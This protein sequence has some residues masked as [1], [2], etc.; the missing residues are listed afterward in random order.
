MQ[1]AACRSCSAASCCCRVA[2]KTEPAPEPVRAVRTVTVAPQ[3]AGGTLGVCRRGARPHRV[4]ARLPGRRQDPA[5]PRRPGQHRQG[6][7]GAGATRSAGP[8]SSARTPRAPRWRPRRPTSTLPAADFK[9]F[10]ELR[11]QGFISAAELER[12]ETTLK[13]A[14]AQLD[15]ARAQASVQGNQAGYATLRGGRRRRDHG[16]GCRARHGR[17]AGTP[18]ACAWPTTARATWCSRCPKTRSALMKALAAQP[19]T[20]KVRLWGRRR[21][22]CRRTVREVAAAADPVTRT[23][24]VKADVGTRGVGAAR[25]DGHGAASSC[26]RWPA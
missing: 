23:F 18:G 24:L 26:R 12:R 8:A 9:R 5:P 10:K 21:R 20:L 15:Q 22:R 1:D 25:A 11:D 3:T 6:R 13:A 7:A 16:G 19:G 14:R 4:A 2:R 17:A